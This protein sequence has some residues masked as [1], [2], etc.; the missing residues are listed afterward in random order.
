MVMSDQTPVNINDSNFIIILN[1]HP[2]NGT[3]WV[4]VIRR[5]GGKICYFDRFGVET[6]P[7][8]LKEYIDLGSDERIQEYNDSYSGAYCLYLIYYIDN[9][10]GTKCALSSLVNQVKCP[11]VYNKCLRCKAKGK[12]E[13]NQGTCLACHEQSSLVNHRRSLFADGNGNVNQGTCFT[14]IN[15]KD[16]VSD[17]VNGNVNDN[18]NDNVN[19]NVIG[20]VNQGTC[21]TDVNGKDIVNDN[22]N[23]NVNDNVNS[24]VNGNV[25]DNVSGNVNDNV[26]DNVNGNVNGNVNQGTCFTDVNGKDVVNDN[27]N[28]NVNDNVNGNVNGNVNDNVNGNV[29]DNVNGNVNGNVNDNVNGNVNDN[30]NGNINGNVNQGTCFADVNA[31][32]KLLTSLS[33]DT[34]SDSNDPVWSESHRYMN[35]FSKTKQ[36]DKPCSQ[37]GCGWGSNFDLRTSGLGSR[38]ILLTDNNDSLQSRINNIIVNSTF[39]ETFICIISSPNE[40]GKTVLLKVSI[41]E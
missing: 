1:Q 36:R 39:R 16:I 6:P 32:D 15:G 40:C 20:N 24:N 17:N 27:V 2:T 29:N 30:V 38:S 7:L 35:I 25:N 37:C 19:G 33:D 8:F 26:N 9:G 4:L 22:V 21:F 28:G 3:H 41:F 11:E 31:N 5:R 14:D 34:Y 18:V 10:Y 13:V 23:G 12:V